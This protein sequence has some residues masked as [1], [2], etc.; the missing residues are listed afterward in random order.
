MLPLLTDINECADKDSSPC[1]MICTNT[2]GNYT[3]SCPSGY[4]GDGKKNGTGCIRQFPALKVAIG[5][6]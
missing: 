1:S 6:F 4:T 5:K 3:C 2:H